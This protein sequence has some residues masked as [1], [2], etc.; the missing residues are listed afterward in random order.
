MNVLL[1]KID[2]TRALK[3]IFAMF[4]IIF[5]SIILMYMYGLLTQLMF[6]ASVGIWVATICIS[7][8]F[9]F[10]LSSFYLTRDIDKIKIELDGLKQQ[11]SLQKVQKLKGITTTMVKLLPEEIA[12]L[13]VDIENFPRN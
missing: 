8:M 9:G 13:S 2:F 12:S 5:F 10:G 4:C 7:V 3:F 6:S 1:K 11:P